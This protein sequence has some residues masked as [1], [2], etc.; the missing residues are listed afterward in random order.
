MTKSKHG[1]K[2]PLPNRLDCGLS[3]NLRSGPSFNF[4]HEPTRVDTNEHLHGAFN[5]VSS[6]R[7]RPERANLFN[8]G[9]KRNKR[10]W[11]VRTTTRLGTRSLGCEGQEWQTNN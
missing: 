3:Q 11:F 8:W 9:Q 5:A 10:L 7:L 6:S 4:C 2:F 1:P